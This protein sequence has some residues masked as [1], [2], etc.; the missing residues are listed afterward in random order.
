[1]IA[2]TKG[3]M[4]IALL[5]TAAWNGAPTASSAFASP[6]DGPAFA[7]LTFSSTQSSGEAT[8]QSSRGGD[9]R[10]DFTG[11]M[12]TPTP[13][14]EVSASHTERRNAVTVTVSA[15]DAGGICTQVVTNNNY[16]GAVT[17][18][19]PGTYVFTILHERTPAHVNTVVV[20]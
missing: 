5:A 14:Y 2:M 4:T 15:A 11:S 12:T 13:C 7:E 10:I 8:P 18:L 20:E 6:A 16:Q 3:L 9:G 1:M 19:E 17:G